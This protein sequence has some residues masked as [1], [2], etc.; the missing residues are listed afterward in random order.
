[1][2]LRPRANHHEPNDV[3]RI[4]SA[5]NLV[6]AHLLQQ[7]LWQAGISAKVFNENATSA[8]G[9]IP[10]THAYPEIW[11]LDERQE[12]RAQALLREF[13]QTQVPAHSLTCAH[14]SEQN[15]GNFFTCWSCGAFLADASG[16]SAV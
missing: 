10:F 14:C 7:L 2:T 16:N 3:K 4:Y 1:L 8:V 6:E 11:L 5:A 12:P 9:E 15:P 13:E